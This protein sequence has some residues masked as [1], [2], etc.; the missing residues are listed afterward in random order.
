MQVPEG[1][2]KSPGEK[3]RR[4]DKVKP[5]RFAQAI[6]VNMLG[7]RFTEMSSASLVSSGEQPF[8]ASRCE[9]WRRRPATA[10]QGAGAVL[11]SSRR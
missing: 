8:A 11:A 6:S 7:M 3:V 1:S 2:W 10:D 4:T 9:R 5:S